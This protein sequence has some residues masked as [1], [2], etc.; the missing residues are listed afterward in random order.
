MAE[1]TIKKPISS[2]AGYTFPQGI[3]TEFFTAE[4]CSGGYVRIGDLVF[5]R[6]YMTQHT[7]FSGASGLFGDGAFPVP[8]D[9]GAVVMNV[10]KP[11]FYPYINSNGALRTNAQTGEVTSGVYTISG[12]YLAG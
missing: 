8:L 4:D 5:V 12:M 10:I 6:L 9:G 7:N 3:N 2:S 11:G 1:S